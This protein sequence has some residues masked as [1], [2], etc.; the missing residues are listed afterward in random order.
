MASL[1]FI[2]LGLNNENGISIQGMDIAKKADIVMIELYTNFMPELNLE[3]LSK[4]LEKEVTILKRSDLEEDA[5]DVILKNA[6]KKNIALLVPGDP[7]VATTHVALRIQAEKAGISTRV[8]H[9]ASI[10]SAVAGA[11]GL[12]VYKFGRTVTIPFNSSASLP[13]SIYSFIKENEES[14]SHTLALLDIDTEKDRY[15]KIDEAIERLLQ[16]EKQ[17][18][19]KIIDEERLA[20]GLSSI[21]SEKAIIKAAR[22]KELSKHRFDS[23]PYSLVLPGKLHFMEKEALITL[24]DASEEDLEG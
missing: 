23:P 13:E 16:M 11:T 3:N 8:I 10:I 22:I 17:I 6:H 24:C 4:L 9:S 15:M 18:K 19:G 14:G 2:G 7:M 20:I 1:S 12:Q 21:G 5:K